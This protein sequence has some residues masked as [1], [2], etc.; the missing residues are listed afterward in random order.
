[1]ID[2]LAGSEYP[3][4]KVVDTFLWEEGYKLNNTN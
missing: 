4:M 1:V 3:T 2:K